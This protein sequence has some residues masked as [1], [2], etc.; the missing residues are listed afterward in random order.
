MISFLG[1]LSGFLMS[2]AALPEAIKTIRKNKHLGT[3]VN[4]SSI[5]FLGIVVSYVYLLGLYG[6]NLLLMVNYGISAVCWFV[7]L[8]YGV[9]KKNVKD[10]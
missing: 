10:Q 5:V 8:F 1:V 2:Y 3:P 7:L 4:V 9:F 6:F